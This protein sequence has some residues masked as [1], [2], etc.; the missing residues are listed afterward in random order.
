VGRQL[1]VIGFGVIASALRSAPAFAADANAEELFQL[2]AAAMAK[3][4]YIRACKAFEDSQALEPQLGTL[5]NLALCHEES[6]KIASAWAEFIEV[7]NLASKQ[8]PPNTERIRICAEHADKLRPRL[9]KLK[10]V[11]LPSVRV[12]QL[13]VRIDNRVV[14]ESLWDSGAPAD[15]GTH[16]I[17]ASAPGRIPFSTKT[18]I[19]EEGA[20]VRIQ[21]LPLQVAPPGAV[22]ALPEPTTGR[23]DQVLAEREASSRTKSI[24]GYII[25]GIG[26]GTIVAGGIFGVLAN[27][28]A[29]D[30][31]VCRRRIDPN[32][33]DPNPTPTIPQDCGIDAPKFRSAADAYARG[34][35]YGNFSNVLIPVGIITLGIGVVLVLTQGSEPPPPAPKKA[36]WWGPGTFRTRTPSTT[37]ALR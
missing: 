13:E 12:P 17:V 6:G 25:G 23:S 36:A 35:L 37:P 5:F 16:T 32:S 20:V 30:A 27:A 15:L 24:A 7:E 34:N 21:V 18:R 22:I 11:V 29:T 33:T 2:G 28:A 31:S 3:K 4:D 8:R 14:P 10:I 19:E 26:L 1:F 9:P